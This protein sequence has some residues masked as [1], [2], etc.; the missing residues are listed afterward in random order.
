MELHEHPRKT[1]YTPNLNLK[2]D[3]CKLALRAG[4]NERDDLHAG[5]IQQ[6]PDIVTILKR[7]EPHV[8]LSHAFVGWRL[9]D[10]DPELADCRG[11]GIFYDPIICL[12]QEGWGGY[13]FRVTIGQEKAEVIKVFINSFK[14]RCSEMMHYYIARDSN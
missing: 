9:G 7:I 6:S 11:K 13:I 3:V 14:K 12:E 2:S 8:P 1:L 4:T 10:M 5:G